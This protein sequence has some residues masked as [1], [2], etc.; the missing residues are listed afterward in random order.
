MHSTSTT[1]PGDRAVLV[2][3][4]LPGV[5]D[6]ELHSSLD[7]LR[8][9]AK[10]LGLRA[11]ARITQPRP[12]A[13]ASTVLGAGKLTELAALTGGTGVVPAGAAKRQTGSKPSEADEPEPEETDDD[14]E[15]ERAGV[16]IFD[17]D[18]TP[19]QIRNLEG[20]TSAEV[21][22]RASVILAIFQRHARTREACLQVEIARLAYLAPRLRATGAGKER[23]RGGIGGKG[24]GESAL[25]L[26]RRRVRDRIAELRRELLAAQQETDIRRSRRAR[27]DTVALVGYTNAGKSSLMR[28]LTGSDV[29]VRDQLFATLDTTIRR[30][31]P[32]TKPAVLVSDTVG[33]IKKLPH[34]LVASFRSTLEEARDAA[35]LLYVVDASD[36]A[37]RSQ[38]EV[39]RSVL[40]EL[41]AGEV[42]S[43]LLLN[44]ADR[45]S[46]EERQTLAEEL[47]AA[48]LLSAHDAQDVVD[49]HGRIV[50]FFE[51][52][53]VEALLLVEY[54]RSRLTHRIHESCRV[55]GEE[56]GEDGTSLRVR[57]CPD[58]VAQIVA[59]GARRVA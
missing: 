50:A 41:D 19:S 13:N 34:D 28:G 59:E 1:G 40:A 35:L 38:L 45:L 26:D 20:A 18:L 22:D 4:Q 58:L 39:T 52:G 55:L 6:A 32:P 17:H 3:I 8:R 7:E 14:V 29:L 46:D 25:E 53:M 16:V 27:R 57:A 10:T 51:R 24:A 15:S 43:L 48:V 30:L 31:S 2:A 5:T 44:K 42:P 33:F 36:P 56:H 54:S 23:Q 49:L 9:L 37:W 47:P 21:L 11:V 12:N